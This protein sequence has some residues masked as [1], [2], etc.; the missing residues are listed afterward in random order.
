MG[1]YGW[2]PPAL[3]SLSSDRQRSR[4]WSGVSEP[5]TPQCKIEA[6]EK[7]EEVAHGG[8]RATS[9]RGIGRGENAGIDLGP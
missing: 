2:G 1:K 8:N 4:E 6:G 7:W 9:K 3:R 5:T